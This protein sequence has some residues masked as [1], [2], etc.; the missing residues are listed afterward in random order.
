MNGKRNGIIYLNKETVE[1]ACDPGSFFI[2]NAGFLFLFCVII[3]MPVSV[4]LGLFKDRLDAKAYFVLGSV[5]SYAVMAIVCAAFIIGYR[6]RVSAGIRA[7][8][9]RSCM[10]AVFAQSAVYPFLL[11]VSNLCAY[12][13]PDLTLDAG[14]ETESVLIDIGFPVGYVILALIPSVVEELI[15]RGVIYGAVRNKS[16]LSAVVV[17]TLCFSLMH[18]NID[19]IAYTAFFGI[20][21][22]FIREYSGSVFP[23]ILA[24]L[25][26]NSTGTWLIYFP[27]ENGSG[28]SNPQSGFMAEHG[29]LLALSVVGIVVS[30]VL[31]DLIK[32]SSNY[33]SEGPAREDRDASMPILAYA[34]GW[35]V[36]AAA[37]ILRLIGA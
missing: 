14:S 30:I 21:L 9:W 32:K 31:V 6:Q 1:L 20:L 7:A 24:H 35:A 10:L 34:I 36:C 37:V 25:A 22:C 28:D 5:L 23:C 15:C 13:M 17:S 27:A 3:P 2:R 33:E 18:H 29:L 16:M 26:F 4:L 11:F 8:G 19:Q 12:L